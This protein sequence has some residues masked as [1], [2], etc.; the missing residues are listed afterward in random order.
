[1][2]KEYTVRDLKKIIS[3]TYPKDHPSQAGALRGTLSSVLS[4]V[5]LHDPEMF[6]AIME[7]E[8]KVSKSIF[9]D[10]MQEHLRSA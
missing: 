8:M 10:V 7:F 9:A 1:M 5:T 2:S 6:K 4:H 3:D